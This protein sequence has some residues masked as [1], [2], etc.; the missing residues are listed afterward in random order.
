MREVRFG[1]VGLGWFGEKH[2]QVLSQLPNVKVVAVSSRRASRAE[3]VA[4]RYGIP[5]WYSD[6]RKLAGDEEVD[7]VSVVTH[8]P[9]HREPVIAATEAGKDVIVEKPIAG[10]LEDADAMIRAAEKSGVIFMVGHILRFENRYTQAKQAIEQG[11]VGRIVSVYARR[12][13]PRGFARPHLRYGSP[14]LLDAIHDIDL[15]MWYLGDRVESTYA[16]FLNASGSENPEVTW[17]VYNF[18]GGAKAVCESVWFLPDNTPYAID[19]KMEVLGTDGAIYIDCAESG[20]MINDRDGSKKPDT[21]HW[22]VMHGR[23]TAALREEL[24]YFVNCVE[25]DKKPEVV[26]PREARE[27]LAVVLAA[28]ESA[29]KQEIVFL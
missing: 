27:A 29:K 11:R 22:P 2:L 8:V 18:R 17:S 4:R 15:I 20:L 3:E 13:I 24:S 21:I 6:W 14:I 25:Q 12:N 10:N 5:R 26:T 19:A 7:A 9:D 23:V 1:V 16:T 28:E